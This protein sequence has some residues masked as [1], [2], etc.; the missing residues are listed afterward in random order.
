MRRGVGRSG[1]VS[2]P[3][4]ISVSS[5]S[6]V[7]SGRM[8]SMILVVLSGGRNAEDGRVLWLLAWQ[9]VGGIE[10]EAGA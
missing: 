9:L 7:S 1:S 10:F 8:M 4:G 2:V 5:A 3:D 6:L